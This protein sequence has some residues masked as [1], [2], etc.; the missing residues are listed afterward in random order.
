M[1]TGVV[2]GPGPKRWSMDLGSMFC[3]RPCNWRQVCFAGHRSHQNKKAISNTDDVRVTRDSQEF[4]EQKFHCIIL[5]KIPRGGI[6]TK[7][8]EISL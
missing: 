4:H 6:C 2:H 7:W 5:M 8:V 1:S 3:I